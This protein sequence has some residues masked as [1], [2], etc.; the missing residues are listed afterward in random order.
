MIA[1]LVVR[2]EHDQKCT[3]YINHV[4][5]GYIYIDSSKDNDYLYLQFLFTYRGVGREIL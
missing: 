5:T 1:N 4:H 2:W 3:T